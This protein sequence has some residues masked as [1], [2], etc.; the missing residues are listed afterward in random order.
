MNGRVAGSRMATD[1]TIGPVP[2]APHPSF[3]PLPTWAAAAATL[4]AAGGY[5]VAFGTTWGAAAVLVAMPCLFLLGRLAT[6]RRAFYGGL[7]AGLAIYVAQL[8]FFGAIF[9]RAAVPIWLI[10]GLPVAVF[11]LLLNGVGRRWGATAGVCLAPVLWTGVEYLRSELNPL[12]FAWLL[13]GQ[14]MAFLPGARLLWAG[15]YGAGFLYA[16]AATLVVARRWSSRLVGAAATLVLAVAMYWP[17]RGPVVAAANDLHVAGMQLEF[18]HEDAAVAALDRLAVAHPEAQVLVLSEYTFL[19]PVPPAVRDVVRRH[20]RYLVAGAEHK[21]DG[22]R[23]YDVA[24][25]VG[26]DGRDVF[27]QAKSVPVQFMADG[28]PAPARRVWRSPWGPIG[29]AVCYDVS[30]ADVMDDFVRQGARGL[31]VPTMDLEKWGDYERRFLHGRMAPT[32]SAEYGIP[33]FG[34]WSSGRSQLTDRAGRVIAAAGY[35]GQGETIAGPFDV[36]HAG[37]VPVDRPVAMAATV[38]TGGIAS[39]LLLARVVKRRRPGRPSG[40]P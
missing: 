34:L 35:P 11:T 31:I 9:G 27:E 17:A 12:R 29:L 23:Y 24:A 7:L 14:A 28:L 25:V 33:V 16:V 19:G 22:D 6:P 37:H 8:W 32:R 4:V 36:S 13:P 21:L 20:R 26:P 39:W 18:P 5:A 40:A 10:A 1:G 15:V 2:D 30:Y 38:V 3:R